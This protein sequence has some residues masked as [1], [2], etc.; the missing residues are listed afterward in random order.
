MYDWA[1]ANGWFRPS[2]PAHTSPRFIAGFTTARQDHAH[3]VD[4]APD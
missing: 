4:G 3:F 1:V 2:K